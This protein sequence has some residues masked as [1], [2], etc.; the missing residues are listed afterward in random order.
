MADIIVFTPKAELDAEENLR[1]F[2]AMCKNQLTIFGAD[3]QFDDVMWDVTDALQL[4]SMGRKRTRITFSSMATAN[5]DNPSPMAEPFASFAK[6]YIR[7]MQGMRPTKIIAGR[8][9]AL[10]ALEAAITE[11]H[12]EQS[13]T[14]QMDAAAFNRAAQLIKEHFSADTAYRN[15]AQLELISDFITNNRLTTIPIQWKNPIRRPNGTARVGKEFDERRANK[16]PSTAAL[17]AL[18]KAFRMA[19]EPSDVI[20]SSIAAIL[21]SAPDRVNEVLLLPADCEVHQKNRDGSMAYGLRWWPAK[22]ADP[23]VKWVVPSMVEVVK[24][25]IS[26]IRNITAEARTIA[27]WYEK[28]PSK[29]FLPTEIEYLR[30]KEYLTTQEA[31]S[32]LYEWELGKGKSLIWCK[33]NGVSTSKDSKGGYLIK[34]ADLETA[35]L[36]KLPEGFPFLNRELG[37]KFSDA[38][39][40]FKMNALNSNK[41]AFN[42]L[43]ETVTINQVNTGL[44]ARAEHGFASVFSKLGLTEP[45]GSPIKVTTHQFRHYLNTLAQA[46]GMSQLDIAKWS[47]RKDINQNNAYDHVPANEI[48]AKI[49]N[50]LGDDLQMFGPLSELPKQVIIHRDEFARLIVPSAHTTELGVCIHDYTMSPCQLHADCINCNEQ[51]C[52]KGDKVRSERIHAEL[53]AAKES[54]AAAQQAVGE[55]YFGANRWAEH[56]S[57][58]V[59]RLSQLC[60][61]LDNPDVPDGAVIQL[62]NI[63]VASRID[64]AEQ[65]RSGNNSLQDSTPALPLS[66][67]CNLLAGME[68]FNG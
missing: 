27:A 60:A 13:L 5:S 19:T 17:E 65:I 58:T 54:L 2:I 37:L 38:L 51:V 53:V 23:M 64:Q 56:H 59:E 49:R 50:S 15:G 12:T 57:K 33:T 66:D 24:E 18:P 55:G 10:R 4:K 16:M 1:G 30:H 62:S 67:M 42:S 34:F 11:M 32:V 31:G 39:F 35:L 47:G 36:S 48:I 3:L 9:A 52:I 14:S 45:D 21:C 8:V 61:I 20:Y 22:G 68:N 26:R 7:Y 40:S 44:G 63:P 28:H 25:A 6:A 41:A 29:I 43:L 46:G